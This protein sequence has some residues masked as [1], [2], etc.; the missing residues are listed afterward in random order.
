MTRSDWLEAMLTDLQ[1]LVIDLN[2]SEDYDLAAVAQE[3]LIKTDHLLLRLTELGI[4]E[5]EQ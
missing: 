4:H 1:K 3:V 5:I 2:K